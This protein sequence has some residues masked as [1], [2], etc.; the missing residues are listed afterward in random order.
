MGYYELE[1][2]ENKDP[3]DYS[4]HE[5][6]AELLRF[7]IDAGHPDR[8]SPTKMGER[9]DVDKSTITR[10]MQRIADEI[11]ENLTSDAEMVTSIVYRKAIR[12]LMGNDDYLDA[13]EVVESWNNWLFDMGKQQKT[14]DEIDVNADASAAYMEM[15][16]E[17]GAVD[18]EDF[19]D[20]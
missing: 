8:I 11:H 5:R 15:L 9:Y 10:D 7:A 3:R 17:A 4:Y 19:D 16:R 14:P 6:R 2:P 20:E 13:V 12:E 18:D 1:V